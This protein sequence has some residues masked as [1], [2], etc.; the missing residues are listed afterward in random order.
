MNT[1]E[2][3]PGKRYQYQGHRVCLRRVLDLQAVLV[4]YEATGALERVTI[5]SLEPLPGGPYT[6]GP[7]LPSDELLSISD[8]AWAR[9]QQKLVILQP[10]LQRRGDMAL[11]E[12]T[13]REHGMSQ[14][15]LY[16]WLR[17]YEQTGSVRSLVEQPHTGGK[18]KKRLDKALDA[19][20]Q[21]AIET[22]YLTPQ[23][24]PVAKVILEIRQQCRHAGLTPPGANTVR[25]RIRQISEEEKTRLR[26]SKR[27]AR[28][29]FEPLKGSGPSAE[30]PL[31]LVEIDHTLVDL[32][33]VDE[34]H[35]QPLGRPW[36]TMAIDNYSRMVAGFYL[37]FD[38]PG[39]I[40]TGLCMAHM[41]LPKEL[42]LSRLDVQGEWPCWGVPGVL[43]AD[44]AREFR[45][46][47]LGRA[48]EKYKIRLDWRPVA[49]PHWGGHIERLMGTF[50]QEVH[51]LPGTTFSNTRDRKDY[52]S[53]GKASLTLREFE[54]WL[55]T[56]I[57][58]VYHRRVHQGTKQIPYER[59]RQGIFGGPDQPGTGL[60]ERLYDELQVRLDF[61]PSEERTVQEYG[62][63][64]DHVHYYADVL[65]PY[66]NSLEPG[67]GKSRIKRK[68]VF[69]R[70]PRD[71][72]CLYFLDP[73]TRL[74]HRIPYRDTS[75]PAISIWEFRRAVE[76]ARLKGLEN[77]SEDSIFHAYDNMRTIELAAVE[78]T[79]RVS[80]SSNR[81]RQGVPITATSVFFQDGAI[82]N[83]VVHSAPAATTTV[84]VE[85]EEAAPSSPLPVV[86]RSRPLITAFDELDD[87]ASSTF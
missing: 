12:A 87:D 36:L 68:F 71:I 5:G 57:V 53:A 76:Q 14:S 9:A 60:Q 38:P 55:T 66:I 56:F 23:K 58:N 3:L 74:Y 69:K 24:K 20:I 8:K 43:Q 83:H 61:M 21:Q 80:K 19:I 27:I 15:T 6:A 42:W 47:M 11:V 31:A 34:V 39:A 51:S 7:I 54:R 52:D 46:K 70:D 29:Q 26:W 63:L 4:E 67:A 79:R 10:I 33:L 59:Y 32:I 28:E 84:S 82:T 85:G 65:K 50:M 17:A 2:L 81:M 86:T 37:S 48:C 41:L 13:A 78:K 25:R 64:I 62:V 77:L 22:H 35:R 40:G 18:G 30:S 1:I 75:H 73:Q 72:S 45:G 49:T 44:N 16:R